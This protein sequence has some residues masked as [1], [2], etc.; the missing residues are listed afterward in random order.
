MDLGRSNASLRRVLAIYSE[1]TNLSYLMSHPYLLVGL[2]FQA[3][4]FIDAIRREEWIWAVCIFVFSVFSALLYYF[5]VYRQAGPA[6]GGMRGF[7]LPGAGTRRRIKE[8]QGRIH[9]LDNARH[10]LDLADVYFSQ[11]KL[12]K[13][14]ASYRASLERDPGDRDAIAHLGQCLLRQKR[15]AEARPLLEQVISA[16]PKH[17]YGHTLMALAETQAALGEKEAAFRS[18]QRVLGNH[19]YA[20]AKVQYAELL[21]ERGDQAAARHELNEVIEDDLHAPRFQR[22]RDKVWVRRARSLLR[23]L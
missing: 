2:A 18:W 3:W 1:I 13:A 12:T 14:E 20:R 7:E 17:D 22:G 6:G 5:F 16:D 19:G 10:H 15:A 4:M 9:H 23:R 11:G 8:L 21:L